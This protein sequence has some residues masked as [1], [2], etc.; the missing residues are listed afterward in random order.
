MC[1]TSRP[2]PDRCQPHGRQPEQPQL[3]QAELEQP[4]PGCPS[5]GPYTFGTPQTADAGLGPVPYGDSGWNDRH[6][7]PARPRP[8][9]G[10]DSGIR[11]PISSRPAISG[12]VARAVCA[13]ALG[14]LFVV[15]MA[16]PAAAGPALA[17]PPAS[18]DEVISR[19]TTWIVRLA[20]GLATLFITYGAVRLLTAGGDPGAAEKGKAAIRG[21]AFGYMLALLAPLIVGVLSSFVS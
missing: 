5:S 16:G 2:H 15:A 3:E 10:Q 13:A 1:H 7:S 9:A 21:A 6:T 12:A 11:R 4:Q 8:D 19:I 20:F 18:L 17:A 14:G